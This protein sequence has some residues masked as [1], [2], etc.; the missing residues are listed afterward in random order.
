MATRNVR[1][2]TP[3]RINLRG[4]D[5]YLGLQAALV[6][7]LPTCGIRFNS[8]KLSHMA[9]GATVTLGLEVD[10]LSEQS[11]EFVSGVVHAVLCRWHRGKRLGSQSLVKVSDG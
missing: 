6:K 8:L 10:S 1:I 2:V 7:T 4:A 5:R 9:T 11:G 3:F